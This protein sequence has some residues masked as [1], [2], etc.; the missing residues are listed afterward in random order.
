MHVCIFENSQ[1]EGSYM[2]D[3]LYIIS[4]SIYPSVDIVCFYM[5]AIVNNAAVNIEAHISF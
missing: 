4:L 5:L 2:G 3:L 1:L